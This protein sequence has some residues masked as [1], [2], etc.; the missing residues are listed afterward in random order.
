MMHLKKAKENEFDKEISE[1]PEPVII[2]KK[3]QW[4]VEKIVRAKVQNDLPD[5]VVKWKGYSDAT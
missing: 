4:V 5:Y 2:K 3:S 1:V